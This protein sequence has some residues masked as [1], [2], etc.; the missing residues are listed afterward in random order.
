MD[1]EVTAMIRSLVAEQAAQR[2]IIDHLMLYAWAKLPRQQR[3]DVAGRLLDTSMQTA[4]LAGIAAGD[5]LKA[6][7]LAEI[8]ERM[9]TSIDQF[10]GRALKTI[11]D[12]EDEA[13]LRRFQEGESR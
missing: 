8:T 9:Q 4:H 5:E 10:V 11:G 1:E 6:A 7:N 12:A 2:Y 3:L 13:A